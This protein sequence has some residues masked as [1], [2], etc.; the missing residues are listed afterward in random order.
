MDRNSTGESPLG[1]STLLRM[2][3]MSNHFVPASRGGIYIE[4]SYFMRQVPRDWI[5]EVLCKEQPFSIIW[6]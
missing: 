4:S 3:S 6:R 1:P 2:V 5:A